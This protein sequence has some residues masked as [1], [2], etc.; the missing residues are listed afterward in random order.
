MFVTG[1][2]I[3]TSS[4]SATV[5]VHQR[6]GTMLGRTYPQQQQPQSLQALA[7][8]KSL[9]LRQS[10]SLRTSQRC[11]SLNYN[12]GNDADYSPDFSNAEIE[13]KNKG[14]LVIAVAEVLSQFNGVATVC[15]SPK[16]SSINLNQVACVV[17][18]DA[19]IYSAS[20]VD[21][22]THCCFTDA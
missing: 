18:F 1:T 9:C 16:S 22:A 21:K 6:I 20:A 4:Y 13:F 11:C 3:F 10:Q 12:S 17:A 2:P 15:I 8:S 14:F 5:S 7:R 19:L